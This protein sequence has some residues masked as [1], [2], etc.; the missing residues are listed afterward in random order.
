[1]R[2]FVVFKHAHFHG[3]R[4]ADAAAFA[5]GATLLGGSGQVEVGAGLAVGH[6]HKEFIGEDH[7]G[8]A[9]VAAF[10]ASDVQDNAVDADIID[11]VDFH[12]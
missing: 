9:A 10:E 1:M 2:S 7:I 11:G 4:G 12:Q 8:Q 5:I 3:L 6:L